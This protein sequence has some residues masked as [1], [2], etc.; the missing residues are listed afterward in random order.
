MLS[1]CF[2]RLSTRVF[3]NGL[4]HN[5]GVEEMAPVFEGHEV[6]SIQLIMNKDGLWT[7]W[8]IFSF[9]DK[10]KAQHAI[11]SFNDYD[12]HLLKDDKKPWKESFKRRL[13][14]W[15][16]IQNIHQEISQQNIE[17]LCRN[18]GEV[19]AINMPTTEDGSH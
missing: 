19:R 6:E 16:V 3:V 11:D 12:M 10:E 13:G 7:G 18:V 8:A 17:Y 1:A 15:V 9:S 14:R 4:P 5:W 2:R